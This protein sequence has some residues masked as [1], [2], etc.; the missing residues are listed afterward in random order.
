MFSYDCD[1]SI[2]FHLDE[3]NLKF[4]NI[5][6][7]GCLIL[8]VF[9]SF[10]FS[11]HAGTIA[12][13]SSLASIIPMFCIIWKHGRERARQMYKKP[14]LLLSWLTVLVKFSFNA[15]SMCAIHGKTF[16]TSAKDSY[17]LL[18]KNPMSYLVI[19]NVSRDYM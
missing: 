4:G 2:I 14:I 10:F 11:Y 7:Y 8:N 18:M 9:Y 12:F 19:N 5:C 3:N 17:I 1:V 13:A 6:I 16:Y 15:L